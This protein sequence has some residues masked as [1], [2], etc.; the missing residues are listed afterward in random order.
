MTKYLF[1]FTFIFAV[2][3]IKAQ[4]N[5]KEI[6]EATPEMKKG[7]IYTG[8]DVRDSKKNYPQGA[9]I[10]SAGTEKEYPFAKI[11]TKKS[12]ILF[13]FNEK[14]DGEIVYMHVY[15]YDLKNYEKVL[16]ASYVF[17]DGKATEKTT[18]T[19]TIELTLEDKLIIKEK[20]N[21]KLKV[22][23]YT[24]GKKRLEYE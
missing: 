5:I 12:I 3:T 19:S 22:K 1:L 17:N 7:K 8:K 16:S 6:I 23:K 21:S 24:V 2:F 13:A 11:L 14:Y 4:T 9:Y 20:E 10:A 15:T 18:Y